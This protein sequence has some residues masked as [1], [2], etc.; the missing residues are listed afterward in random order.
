MEQR[1]LRRTGE[2]EANSQL[3]ISTAAFRIAILKRVKIVY[4]KSTVA[5]VV[6]VVVFGLFYFGARL[7][8]ERIDVHLTL[9][10]SAIVSLGTDVLAVYLWATTHLLLLSLASIVFAIAFYWELRRAS[11]RL[12]A[13]R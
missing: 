3:G 1:W 6:A 12:S 11:R 10:P 2:S 5:G 4:F 13:Q 8:P 7:Y 9:V